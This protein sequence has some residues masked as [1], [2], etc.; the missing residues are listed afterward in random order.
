MSQATDLLKRKANV[1]QLYKARIHGLEQRGREYWACCPFHAEKTASFK[2]DDR[3]G[4]WLFHCKGCGKGGDILKFIVENDHVT[5]PEAIAVL[6]K[7]AG[8]GSEYFQQAQKVTDA[9][10]P[11]GDGKPMKVVSLD[12]SAQMEASLQSNADALRWLKEERGI[13]AETAQRLHLGY[14]QSCPYASKDHQDV[15]DAGW[16]TFPRI[17]GGRVVAVKYRSIKSKVFAQMPGMNPRALFNVETIVPLDPVFV[18]EGE[19]DTAIFEQAGFHAVSLPNATSDIGPAGRTALKLAS[20]IYLAGDND[21]SGNAQMKKLAMELG[22]STYLIQWPDAK[23][24]NEFFLKVCK[25]DIAEFQTRVGVLQ[26]EAHGRP[27]EN[28]FSLVD[29]LRAGEDDIDPANDP[30]RLHFPKYLPDV[31]HMNY[32]PAGSVVILYSTYTG[33]GKTILKTQILLEEAMRGEVVVDFSPEVQGDQYKTLVTSQI[34][35]PTRG[36][37]GLPRNRKITRQEMCEAADTLTEGGHSISYYVCHQI[38]A[39]GS[40]DIL[41]FIEHV[42]KVTGCTRFAL[43]TFH[44]VVAAESGENVTAAE[45][46]FAKELEKLAIKYNMIFLLICQSNAEAEGIDNRRKNEHGVLRGNREVQDATASI[47]LLHRNKLPNR[48]GEEQPSVLDLEGGIFLKKD[49][50]KGPGKPQVR[51]ALNEACSLFYQ[52]ADRRS[53][54]YHEEEM[55]M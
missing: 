28:V 3:R 43:D 6:E 31:D 46:R 48:D 40:R 33:T 16:I 55:P 15:K 2:I 47:Y 42:I 39:S 17:E 24:A 13:T 32:T 35:G 29:S 41:E 27:A 36:A 49:R 25:G 21:A 50:Y 26:S 1:L 34:V 54:P 18:T 20:R 9:V 5:F 52:T 11:L 14:V 22:E 8:P 44:K 30:R 37:A 53:V 4:D 38:P 23:D 12:E 10:K 7:S 51:V 19:L 45:G